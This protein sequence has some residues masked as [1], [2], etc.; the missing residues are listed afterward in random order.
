MN[1]IKWFD[2]VR[3]FGLFLVLGYH[4]FHSALPGGFLGVDVFFTFSGF[5]IT[6]LI[7]E[8]VRKNGDFAVFKYFK[9][10]VQRI[11][12]PMYLSIAFTL[13]FA[14]LISP[15]FTV[16]IAKQL[17]SALSF[18]ANW[19]NIFS[20]SSYEAQ[21]MPQLY[22][23]M[24]SLAVLMQFYV[25]WGI[26][27][28]LLSSVSKAIYKKY[29][30]KRLLFLNGAVLTIS[31]LVAIGSYMFLRLQIVSEIGLN[32]IYFNTLSRLFPFFIGA[33]AGAIWGINSKQDKAIKKRLLS[34]HKKQK[35]AAMIIVSVASAAV[36]VFIFSQYDFNDLFI[37]KYG[38]VLTSA[39]TVVM[40]YCTHGLHILTPVKMKEPAALTI[41]SEMSYDLYLFHWPIYIIVSAVV[42]NH[43]AAS[44]T[45][46]AVSISFS[47]LMVY[48]VEKALFAGNGGKG[49]KHRRI[50]LAA[51][52][53]VTAAGVALGGF[54]V[55]KAPAI[56]S[57][58][59]DFVANYVASDVHDMLLMSQKA[60]Y[61]RR[62]DEMSASLKSLS[63]EGTDSELGEE[64]QVSEESSQSGGEMQGEAALQGSIDEEGIGA[65]QGSA[66]EGIGA[67]QGSADGAGALQG[68]ADGAG[69]LQ[70][71]MENGDGADGGNQNN[72]AQPQSTAQGQA[73]TAQGQ[74]SA[75][76]TAQGQGATQTAKGQDS[77]AQT[78]QGQ[79][80]TTLTAQGQGSATQTAQGQGADVGEDG[81]T[82]PAATTDDIGDDSGDTEPEDRKWPE[83]VTLIGD[84]VPLGAKSAM[85]RT[86]PNCVVDAEVSRTVPQ[87]RNIM[88]NL[89]N[90]GELREYVVIAVGTNANYDYAEQL[91][92]IVTAL[93][94][95]HRLIFVTPYDG[96]NNTNGRLTKETAE[97]LRGLSWQYDY[98]TIADWNY[99]VG[100]QANVLA[101][102]KVHMGGSASMELYA[103]MVLD[104]VNVASQKPAK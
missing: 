80:S 91:L 51:I 26:V 70:G 79:G 4:L 83:G 66:E 60:D 57:I 45:T 81:A 53:A 68:S 5:L 24:W 29:S 41:A 36:I 44:L 20:G 42:L 61:G 9:R 3:A 37:Y 74:G 19:F 100:E 17:A 25:A 12:V 10:R 28:A 95:G 96:N 35:A 16:G 14:L 71:A 101:A 77:V 102:D 87:G 94:P 22:M 65:E 34:E 40:I 2:S 43:I 88:V 93:E 38:F 33:T 56:T 54:V 59:A 72:N 13:P 98:I 99:I 47:A 15:D 30:S 46:L 76:Q 48:I 49:M 86:I 18:T 78:A 1:R 6:A 55:Y 23:H 11:L 97:W 82:P 21:L 63:H 64:R 52:G 32:D 27:C 84:S 75:T 103:Q 8:E 90:K 69:A 31:L 58:E 67:L 89:Q 50:A 73:Q 39:L 85:T 92:K 104:A 62:A 7:M